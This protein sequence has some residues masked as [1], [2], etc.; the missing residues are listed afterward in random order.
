M[1]RKAAVKAWV[2]E[3]NRGCRKRA[4]RP[5]FVPLACVVDNA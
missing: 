4:T 2:V 3:A 5:E 1:K